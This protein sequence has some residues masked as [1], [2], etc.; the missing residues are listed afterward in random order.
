MENVHG[1]DL[2]ERTVLGLDDEE[3]DD[4]GKT[5]T[6]ATEDETEEPVDLVDDNSGE[7]RDQEVPDPVGSSG[8]THAGGTVAGRVELSN[9]GPDEGTPGGGER[10]D[11]QASEDD[12]NTSGGGVVVVSERRKLEVTD[13]GVDH[14]TDESP[15]STD[16]EGLAATTLGNNVKTT[17]SADNVDGTENDLGD[18]GVAETSSLENGCTVVEEEVGTGKL[19]TSLESHPENSTVGHTGTSEALVPL[20]ADSGSLLVK[21]DTNVVDLVADFLVFGVDTGVAGNDVAGL[22]L[23]TGAVGETGRLGEEEDTDT[24]DEGPEERDTVGD[25]PLSAV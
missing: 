10:D 11:E 17:E 9:D 13:K 2:L 22:V 23:T 6:A 16:N 15:E 12:Q 3:V 8:K 7:E 19:L 5:K 4:D 18:V 20:G 21:L 25:S 1:V 24:E 14:E